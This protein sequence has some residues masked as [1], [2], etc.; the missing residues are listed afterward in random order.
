M[1]EEE[2][3]RLI[4]KYY[5]GEST[6]E[7]ESSLRDYFRNDNIPEGYE[8]EKLIF[9]YYNESDG[10][11]EPS[12][13]FESRILA[14]IDASEKERGSRKMKKYLLPLLSTA[15]GLLILAGSYFFFIH[16]AE[17]MDTFK[18]PEIAYTE[19]IKI[20][21]NVSS[22]LNR[23]AQVLEPVGKINEMKIKSIETI[24]K[25][26]S[27]VEKKLNYLQKTIGVTQNPSDNNINK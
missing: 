19:T 21:L 20:L 7:E 8:A 14:G 26:T 3:K 6:E 17:S 5:N 12:L 24:N 23:G 15:A 13:D 2:L 27:L 10:V 4:E 9:S 18:D 25:S 1:N 22:Q 16:K 11:P